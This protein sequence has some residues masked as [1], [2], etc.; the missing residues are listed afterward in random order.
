MNQPIGP[1]MHERGFSVQLGSLRFDAWDRRVVRPPTGQLQGYEAKPL[2]TW[3]LGASVAV[4]MLVAVSIGLAAQHANARSA[5]SVVVSVPDPLP[6]RSVVTL[7]KPKAQAASVAKHSPA[8]LTARPA[9]LTTADP[10]ASFPA[11]AATDQP[12]PL[13]SV[14]TAV[15]L[16]MKTGD[17]Q[18]W[19]DLS[20]GARG[21]V[22]V[23]AAQNIGEKSCRD[24]SILTRKD[25][26]PETVEQKRNCEPAI[27]A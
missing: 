14:T 24:L 5:Y 4:C 13:V 25:G 9:L 16:A 2:I 8:G 19:G 12:L 6:K 22:V 26:Q 7:A 10:P 11:V 18:E 20:T 1:I 23:G 3:R 17:A 15:R 27:A 21:I